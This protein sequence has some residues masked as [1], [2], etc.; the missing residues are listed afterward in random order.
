MS[1]VINQR[2]AVYAALKTVCEDKG[3][4]FV[5]GQTVAND[6]SKD[7]RASVISI[8]TEGLMNGTVSLKDTEGN[9]EKKADEA[10]MKEYTN[11]LVSNWFRK[12]TRL[13]GNTKYEIKNPGSRAGAGDETLKEMKKLHKALTDA[14]DDTNA[15]VVKAEIDARLATIRQERAKDVDIN[16]ELLPENLRN[17]L[18]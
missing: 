17:M 3:I 16:V 6:L 7:I 2:Q 11:G 14:G 15:A 1:N 4:E 18:K 9:T 5:D 8:V 10:K 12:D 13:N